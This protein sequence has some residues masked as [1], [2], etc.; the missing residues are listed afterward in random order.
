MN[1]NRASLEIVDS[2]SSP[3]NSGLTVRSRAIYSPFSLNTLSNASISRSVIL[4]SSF[5]KS[6]RFWIA[7][8]VIMAPKKGAARDSAARIN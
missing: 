5:F 7:S 4:I 8:L 3:K 1:V 2:F 6:I